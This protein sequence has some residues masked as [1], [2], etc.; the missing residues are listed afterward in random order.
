MKLYIKQKVFS[1]KDKFNITDVQGNARYY[2][3]GEFLSI[4][5][6]LH[7]FDT[8]G[9]ELALIR[10]KVMTLMPKFFILI[11]GQQVGEIRKK[12]TFITPKYE[13]EGP[14]W[15]VQGS[16]MEHD[17]IITHMDMTVAR[18]HKVWMSWGDSFEIDIKDPRDEL[19]AIAVVLAIDCVMDDENNAAV[20]S[21]S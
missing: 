4:G 10:E 20:Y 13:I 6:K 8:Y 14:G 3:E 2:V 16:F 19:M 17:Y 12:F 9:Q 7:I 21:G 1:I 5:K 15:E 11:N 18:I